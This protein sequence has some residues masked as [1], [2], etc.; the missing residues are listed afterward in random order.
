MFS[1][2]DRMF[3]L[4]KLEQGEEDIAEV[5]SC[6]L[7]IARLLLQ[8]GADRHAR[9]VGESGRQD[10]LISLAQASP[11]TGGPEVVDMLDNVWAQTRSLASTCRIVIRRRLTRPILL[12]GNVDKLPIS[13]VAKRY[14]AME[15]L[16]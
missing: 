11:H 1:F 15:K 8:H 13:G 5:K 9:C 14:V 12:E 4:H 2:P 16:E 7:A 10:D 3:C 6:R